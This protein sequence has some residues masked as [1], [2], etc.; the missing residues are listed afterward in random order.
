MTVNAPLEQKLEL[1]AAQH[2]RKWICNRPDCDGLEHDGWEWRHARTA[3]RMP[4]GDWWAWY[5]RGGRG[6]GKTRSGAEAFGDLIL[7]SPPLE[8][9]ES[10]EWAIVAPTFAD[11]RDVCMEGPSG[12]LRALGSAAGNWNRSIGEL[13]VQN[14]A[15]VFIDGADDGALR[16]QG[17]NLRGVWGDEVGLWRQWDVAWN[18]SIVNA[19]RKSPA[20]RIL[21][22]TPKTGHGL[23]RALLSDPSVVVSHMSMLD[24]R[25]NLHDQ[26]VQALLSRYEGT[27]RGRQE[28]YGEFVEEVMGA[29]WTYDLLERTRHTEAVPDLARVVVG[30][31]PSGASDED[32]GADW[33]GIIAAGY[34]TVT[35]HG[36]VLKDCSVNAGPHTWASAAVN[37]YH[38][39]QA[40]M[41]VAERNFGGEMVRHTLNTIDPGVP[42]KLVTSSRGKVVRAQP[43]ASLYEQG[44]VHHAGVFP[45][46]EEQMCQWVPDDPRAKSPDRMDAVVFALTELMVGRHVTEQHDYRGNYEEPEYRRGE[47]VLRGERYIDK[48]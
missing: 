21:T 2:R 33:I 8:S 25:A 28:L 17:K 43:V 45:E 42:V 30:V 37:L 31:D 44:K 22:G 26:A 47:L 46:L 1:L 14:G 39:L 34:S 6:S 41:I 12:L 23:V 19:V 16:I 27:R 24:N 38:E 7:T 20:K 15:K 40:D 4:D 48:T 10:S 13:Y 11:A 3:Q 35:G 5:L 9:G 32:T 29:L 36:Y 18:E